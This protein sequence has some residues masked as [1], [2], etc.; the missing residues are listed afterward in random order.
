[1]Y[2]YINDFINIKTEKPFISLQ[3]GPLYILIE[4]YRTIDYKSNFNN[5]VIYDY[6][7]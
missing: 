3:N 2:M 1:M 6:H 7:H 5:Q 4:F